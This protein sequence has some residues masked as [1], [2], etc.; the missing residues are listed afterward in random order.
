MARR[1]G[2]KVNDKRIRRMWREEGLRVPQRR[3]KKRLIG[4]GA[5][6]GAMSP[7]RP[8]TTADGRTIKML[9]VIDEFTREALAIAVDRSIDAD[10]VVEVV[11]RLARERGAPSYVHFDHGP[12]FVARAVNDWCRFTGVDSSHLTAVYATNCSTRGTSTRCSKPARS[13]K[14]DATTTTPTGPTLPTTN[15]LQPNSPNDGLRPA[16]LTLHSSRIA[17][18]RWSGL[19]PLCYHKIARCSSIYFVSVNNLKIH[20]FN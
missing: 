6:V 15:S 7:T 11:D 20:I 14:T 10:G 3:R 4:V 2:W 8:N 9:N 1:A 13:S 12:E 16:N 18:T 19:P 5:A 17:E